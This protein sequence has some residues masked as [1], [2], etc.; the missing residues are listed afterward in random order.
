MIRL[1]GYDNCKLT[2]QAIDDAAHASAGILL[3]R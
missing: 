2:T 3:C 1:I